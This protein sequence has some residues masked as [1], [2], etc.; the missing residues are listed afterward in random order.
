MLNGAG[1][2]VRL[3]DKIAIV[4]GAGQSPGEGMGNGRATVLRFVQEGAM[5]MAADRD[6]ASVEETV[7]M[8]REHGPCVAFEADV[9]KE[10]M[11]AA[12]VA[13]AREKFGRIDVLHYNVGLSIAGGDAP[14]TEIT[15]EA[16]DR[17]VAINLR[18]CVMAVKHVLPVMRAQRTGVIL[19]ISSVAAYENYPYVAY[20][21]TKAGMIAFTQQVAIQN[22]EYGIRA[23]CILPGLMNTP[24][25]V[26]TRARHSGKSRAEV[27]AARDAKVPLRGAMGTAWDVANAALFLASDEANFITGVALPVDGGALV[28]IG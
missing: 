22:A 5:V 10:K 6:L 12:M 20:K 13:A 4:V 26:D 9:T 15:E 14:P 7:A 1:N 19:T 17:I 8:A 23:N 24:M 3:K 18:G 2:P 21:A 16:F 11:L 25:A 27:A 28:K